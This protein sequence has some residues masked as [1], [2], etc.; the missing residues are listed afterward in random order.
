M[1]SWD[2]L[3]S[4]RKY[5]WKIVDLSALVAMNDVRIASCSTIALTSRVSIALVTTTICSDLLSR[6]K[7]LS[8]EKPDEPQA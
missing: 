8:E 3:R 2:L 1:I 6:G 5:C 4:I 7:W